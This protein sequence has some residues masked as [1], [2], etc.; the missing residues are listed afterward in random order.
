MLYQIRQFT[1]TTYFNNAL[2]ITIATV[3]PVLL[4]SYLNRF[5][6]GFT[7]AL[8]AFLTYPSDIPSS[9]KHK[10]NGVLFTAIL[11]SSVNLLVNISYPFV[12]LFYPFL[13]LLIFVLSIISVYGQ[14]A[15]VVSFSALLS[16]SLSFANLNWGWKMLAHSGLY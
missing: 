1:D 16:L 13:A 8:G 2:K 4:F 7:I 14:R 11:I 6:L 10:I 3:I 12:H 15:T 9:L 5:Q